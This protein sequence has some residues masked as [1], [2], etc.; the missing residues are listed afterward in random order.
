[1]K[2]FD[3][4]YID[5][6]PID[7]IINHILP[8]TYRIKPTFHLKDI[9]NFVSNYNFIEGI[10]MTEFNEFILLNDLLNLLTITSMDCILHRLFHIKNKDVSKIIEIHFYQN[11]HINTEN[12]VR[13]IWGLLKPRERFYFINKY[14]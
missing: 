10:Y 5:K 8:Y 6:L 4:K 7:V 9:R 11:T 13:I 12:K 2:E 3:K 1:M 14:L